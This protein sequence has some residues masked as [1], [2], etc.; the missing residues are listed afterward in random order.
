[1]SPPSPM[2]NVTDA[3]LRDLVKRSKLTSGK[4][5]RSVAIDYLS[6]L[7]GSKFCRTFLPPMW[8]MGPKSYRIQSVFGFRSPA[9]VIQSVIRSA[10]IQMA[11]FHPVRTWPHVSFQHQLMNTPSNS[12]PCGAQR[13]DFIPTVCCAVYEPLPIMLPV[14]TSPTCFWLTPYPSIL[15][16]CISRISRYVTDFNPINVH[17]R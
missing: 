2:Y 4:K 13:D 8:I 10:P 17:R 14:K 1:M 7:L 12:F 16:Y 6:Y 3:T 11:T 5:A 15:R 9:Q